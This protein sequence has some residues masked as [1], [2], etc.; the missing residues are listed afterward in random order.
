MATLRARDDAMCWVEPAGATYLPVALCEIEIASRPAALQAPTE[1][2]FSG[3]GSVA[4]ISSGALRI[5]VVCRAEV[6]LASLSTMV[7]EDAVLRICVGDESTGNG[8]SANGVQ[9]RVDWANGEILGRTSVTGLPPLFIGRTCGGVWLSTPTLPSN[10]LTSRAREPDLD[11]VADTL[12]WGYPIDGRTLFAGV[13]LLRSAIE[14]VGC[15]SGLQV[16]GEWKPNDRLRP[17][18]Q[19]DLDAQ[20]QAL[21]RS[22]ARLP[23]TGTFLSL[24]GGID[25][26]A[27]LLALLVAGKAVPCVTLAS[28]AASFEA[29]YARRVCAA[30]TLE[31]QI[32]YL[33]HDYFRQLPELVRHAAAI[34]GG[35]GALTQSVEVFLYQCLGRVYSGRISGLFGNQIGRGGVESTAVSRPQLDVL[36]DELGAALRDRPLQP[37]YS[38]RVRNGELGRVLTEEEGCFPSVANYAVGSAFARQLT[39]YADLDLMCLAR[40]SLRQLWRWGGTSQFAFRSRD[41]VHRFAGPMRQKSFQRRLL[42]QMGAEVQ[43]VPLDWGWLARGS[44]APRALLRSAYSVGKWGVVRVIERSPVVSARVGAAL[45]GHKPWELVDWRRA[46]RTELREMVCDTLLAPK[47][48]RTNLVNQHAL[49]KLVDAHFAG[50]T[51]AFDTLAPLF[52]VALSITRA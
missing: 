10:L 21:L 50:K 28:S 7:A 35:I 36:S 23:S 4:T 20:V 3:G 33:G 41:A 49:R 22:A 38:E 47:F 8:W 18:A 6:T 14:F 51:D 26:R 45:G 1:R 15:S 19:D 12:R 9:I 48:L 52:E 17:T 30:C 2:S 11:G 34:T 46:V 42:T 29:E 32:I 27:A 39:P 31:H 25:S 5:K 16:T 44:W 43:R 40:G 13:S 24:S 37:W